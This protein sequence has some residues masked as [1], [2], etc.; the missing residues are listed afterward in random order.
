MQVRESV[1]EDLAARRG[2]PFVVSL[3]LDVDGRRAPRPSDLAPRVDHLFRVARAEA[4]SQGEEASA[5]LE[6]DLAEI[7][8]YLADLD[9]HAT[10]GVALFAGGRSSPLVALTLAVPVADEV[11]LA[12]VAHLAPLLVARRDTRP[13]LVVL[14]DRERSRFV[15]VAD[16]EVEEHGGPA[17][18]VGRRIDTDVE[19]GSFSRQH[20]EARRRHLR[21]VADAVAK[22]RRER[23][24]DC[25]LLG[26]PEAAALEAELDGAVPVAGALTVAM[27]ASAHEVA[28]LAAS[29]RRGI[30]CR[31]EAALVEELT[32]RQGSG[33]ALGVEATLEALAAGRV[34][35]LVVEEGRS[36]AGGRCHV[37]SALARSTAACWRCGGVV[38]PVEDVIAEAIVGAL[39]GGATVEVVEVPELAAAG[40][41]GALER[42]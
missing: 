39:A 36:L 5:A 13:C 42:Y 37:C 26:G 2:E 31:R 32:G 21:A 1:L 34:A 3:Y 22:A 23:P 27:A 12:P 40:G 33:A 38:E 7:G 19:L 15:R 10:R 11:R 28:E 29:S 24:E 17:D 35:T 4:A 30:E 25:V 16:G 8:A 18:G 20:D 9:R 14:V 6:A 41:L